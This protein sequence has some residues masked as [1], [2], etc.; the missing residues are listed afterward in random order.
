VTVLASFSIDLSGLMTYAENIFNGLV[1]AFV[2]ILGII[3]GLGIIF[4]VY[5]AIK[6]AV[7]L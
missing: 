1:P 2:P 7:K 5:E 6:S 3:L 4:L